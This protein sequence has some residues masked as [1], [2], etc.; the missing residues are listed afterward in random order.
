M[1]ISKHVVVFDIELSAS[2]I[3]GSNWHR[4]C[5][6]CPM[7]DLRQQKIA[8]IRFSISV[9]FIFRTYITVDYF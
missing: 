1:N 6:C 7:W 2:R 4:H 8:V 3:N 5:K 9:V